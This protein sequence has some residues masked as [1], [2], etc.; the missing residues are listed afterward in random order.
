MSTENWQ[1]GELQDIPV[2]LSN[3]YP[4][5]I[6]FTAGDLPPSLVG[7]L[8]DEQG[9]R[10]EINLQRTNKPLILAQTCAQPFDFKFVVPDTLQGDFQFGFGMKTGD[11]L[12]RIC[13]QVSTVRIR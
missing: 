10:V 11:L 8:I 13:S 5:L 6:D 2:V 4:H 7:L 12:P 9:D 1:A 3:P